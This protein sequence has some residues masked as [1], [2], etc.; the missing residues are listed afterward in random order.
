MQT[1]TPRWIRAPVALDQYNDA[2]AGNLEQY[3]DNQSNAG[4]I[5]GNE[6]WTDG[7][8]WGGTD[9][10]AINQYNAAIVAN[11]IN[12]ND[13]YDSAQETELVAYSTATQTYELRTTPTKSPSWT[14][15]RPWPRPRKSP[16]EPAGPI[17][18]W[19]CPR[20]PTRCSW[21]RPLLT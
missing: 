13:S 6:L 1:I 14:A 2:S 18:S 4:T 21:P 10:P 15:R 8:H 16:K 17:T 20:M 3:E 19:P 9:Q 7:Y 11:Q 5:Y 12:N